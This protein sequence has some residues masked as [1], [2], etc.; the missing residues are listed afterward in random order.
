MSTPVITESRQGTFPTFQH[1]FAMH[2]P[3]GTDDIR[4]IREQH[5]I[6]NGITKLHS[7][8]TTKQPSF[9]KRLMNDIIDI[10]AG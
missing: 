8:L 5:D 6:H 3:E 4:H 2:L 9:I 1:I 10:R 7:H